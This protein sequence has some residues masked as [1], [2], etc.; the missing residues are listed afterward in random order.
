MQYLYLG[1]LLFSI[2]G[3]VYTDK[4]FELILFPHYKTSAKIIIGSVTFFLLCDILGVILG[5]FSTNSDRV[6]GLFIFSQNM[7]VEELLFLT[8]FSYV[9]LLTWR[10]VCIRTS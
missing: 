2:G 10:I 4:R 7:P 9:T 8:L 6:S 5:V 3:L 1:I